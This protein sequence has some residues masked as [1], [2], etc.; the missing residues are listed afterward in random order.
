VE[1]VDT[2]KAIA[3]DRT[4]EWPSTINPEPEAH[5]SVGVIAVTAPATAWYLPE[6][7]SA[8]GFECWLLIQK[9][10]RRESHVSRDLHDRRSGARDGDEG[11][12]RQFPGEL[13]MARDI[14]A[15]DASI[16]VTSD[17]PVIPERAMYRHDRSEGP[18]TRSVLRRP[19]VRSTSRRARLPGVF[20]TYVLVQNP[21]REPRG[22]RDHLHGPVRVPRGN[23]RFSHARELAKDVKVNDVLQNAG[24]QHPGCRGSK[25]IIAERA[26]YWNVYE[27]EKCHDSIGMDQPHTTFLPAGRGRHGE[28]RRRDLD[29]GAEFPIQAR[30]WLRSRT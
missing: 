22:R 23:R 14:G 4:M 8:W 29:A 5:S 2:G 28:L 17:V 30:S 1:A 10:E 13:D 27:Q 20:T 3:V 24:L 21:E 26:M 25:P 12:R 15:K 9:P 11:G 19:P 18:T 6:G 7:S 16:E